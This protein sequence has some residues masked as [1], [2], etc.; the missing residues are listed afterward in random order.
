MIN[1]IVYRNIVILNC[2]SIRI[3]PHIIIGRFVGKRHFV[4]VTVF[5]NFHSRVV[6]RHLVAVMIRNEIGNRVC[7]HKEVK[8]VVAHFALVILWLYTLKR[9]D[10]PLE[11]VFFIILS[12]K[13][14]YLHFS[15]V[16]VTEVVAQLLDFDLERQI[17]ILYCYIV[18]TRF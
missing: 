1:G 12:F 15:A 2:E 7:A 17:A 9:L 11:V 16:V 10:H 13:A 6:R 14:S 8:S 18:L 3:N 4:E 5:N